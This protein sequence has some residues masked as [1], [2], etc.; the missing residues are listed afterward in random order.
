MEGQVFCKRGVV[1]EIQKSLER[2]IVSGRPQVR[3]L[4]YRYVAWI[5]RDSS[6]FGVPVLRYHNLHE[7]DED[8]HHRVFNPQTGEQILY[9]T[10]GRSQFPVMS[11]ILDEIEAILELYPEE[12]AGQV[13]CSPELP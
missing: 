10:L 2:I 5:P 9:E 8:Y 3:G 13:E 1:L 11:E 6:D 7:R 12:G 4:K